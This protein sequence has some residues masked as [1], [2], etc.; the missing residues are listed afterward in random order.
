MTSA[1]HI[2]SA[3]FDADLEPGEYGRLCAWLHESTDHVAQ[4]VV[5][6]FVHSQLIELLSPDQARANA[7]VAAR[8]LTESAKPRRTRH[9]AIRSLAVAAAIAVV[10]ATTYFAAVRPK[11]V[12]T[13]TGTRNVQWAPGIE[14]RIVGG[15]LQSGDELALEHGTLHLTFAGGAQVALRG[16]ARFRVESDHAGQLLRG[17]LSAYVLEH[18]VGFTI[19]SGHFTVVDL[20]TEFYLERAENDSCELQVFAGLVEVRLAESPDDVTDGGKLQISQG[21]A[22]R[23]EAAAGK[24]KPIDYNKTMRLPDSAWSR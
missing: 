16:P 2:L 12:A 3:Y 11:V 4:F 23:F 6:G 13:V 7:L 18:S 15:L 8:L 22:I 21:S 9:F 24:I 5:E 10:A 14:K 17:R 1:P 19:H 20:G